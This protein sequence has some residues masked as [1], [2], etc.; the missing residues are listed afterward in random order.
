K[1]LK[2]KRDTIPLTAMEQVVA[3]LGEDSLRA[4][5]IPYRENGSIEG[6]NLSEIKGSLKD[7]YLLVAR[8]VADG[9]TTA[10]RMIH[11]ETKKG[12]GIRVGVSRMREIKV[13]AHLYDLAQGEL[14][15]SSWV[16]TEGGNKVEF[17]VKK[18]KRAAQSGL[19]RRLTEEEEPF[20][21]LEP[22]ARMLVEELYPAPKDPALVQIL[23]KAL[24]SLADNLPQK[25]GGDSPP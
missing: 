20:E 9:F 16:K 10:R 1:I 6:G 15:W 3:A 25:K 2:T 4:L 18:D 23:P 24:F 8:V 12:G 19:I 14:V 21:E 7:R 11:P 5:A 13:E 17:F 22:E